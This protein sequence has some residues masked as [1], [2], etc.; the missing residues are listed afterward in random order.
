MTAIATFVAA[1][2]LGA[3][4]MV[5][6]GGEEETA[7]AGGTLRIGDGEDNYISEPAEN[8]TSVGRLRPS[9][10]IFEP[11]T[12]LADDLL[13][14]EPLL[15]ESWELDEATNTWTFTIREGVKFHDDTPLT[16][17]AVATSLQRLTKSGDWSGFLGFEPDG[18]RAIDERTLEVK[19]S[20]PQGGLPS[21]LSTTGAAIDS[22]NADP[23][24]EYVGTG[25]YKFVQYVK[26]Q[27]FVVEK[28]PN[29]WGDPKPTLDRIE[30]RFIP[31][32]NARVL[33]LQ[34]GEI[35]MIIGRAVPAD[36]AATL[37]G[38]E[39]I[40][41]VSTPSGATLYLG[42]LLSGKPPYAKLKDENLREAIGYAIDRQALV[43]SF[44]GFAS[45]EQ[46]LFAPSMLGPF[47]EEIEGYTYDPDRAKSVLEDAGWTDADNDGIRERAG[48]KLSLEMVVGLGGAAIYGQK[49]EIIQAQL[50]DVGIDLKITS[51]PDNAAFIEKLGTKRADF[52]LELARGF[53]GVPCGTL[54]EIFV[55]PE[56]DPGANPFAAAFS[57]ENVG[58]TT[59]TEATSECGAATT[60]ESV[61]LA[62]AKAV[63][64]IVDEARVFIPL[65]QPEDIWA[66]R[67][68]SF[69]PAAA[70]Y[71]INW[72]GISRQGE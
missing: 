55:L 59:V 65:V 71:S 49:P 12:R 18:V 33:A 50:R 40:R 43:D 69:K 5:A 25:P 9:V 41:L 1:T 53:L 34:A 35:D 37:E 30:F 11:L 62:A 51:V 8:F 26:D 66:M 4:A 19:T 54:G 72:T 7:G 36:L 47:A 28:N 60:T 2:A 44:N 56:G 31:D 64:V 68:V 39:G 46:T 57:P 58:I 10:G 67:N 13:T 23:Y 27:R 14:A 17:E 21:L 63:K 52:F 29:Y 20:R 45:D 32:D 38:K 22:P 6:C 3:G 61:Q 48:E 15:A 42:V 16:A 24:T 70:E